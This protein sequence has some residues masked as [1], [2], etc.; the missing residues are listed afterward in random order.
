MASAIGS[1]T[2][3]EDSSR[4]GRGHGLGWEFVHVSDDDASRIAFV[5]MP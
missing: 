1:P 4:R 5:E 3:A 2:T